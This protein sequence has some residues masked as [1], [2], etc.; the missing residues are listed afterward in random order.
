MDVVGIMVS[1]KE[2]LDR[3]Y[4]EEWVGKLH[5]EEEWRAVQEKGESSSE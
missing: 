3:E 1:Q 2:E 5:L 4:I